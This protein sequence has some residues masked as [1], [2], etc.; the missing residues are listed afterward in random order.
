MALNQD[1]IAAMKDFVDFQSHTRFHPVLTTCR[2][3]ECGDEI[4]RSKKEVEKL[5]AKEC[6]HLSYPNGDYTEREIEIVKR[7][8]YRSAR[9]IDVGWNTINTDPYRLKITGIDDDA[10]INMLAAQ[11]TGVIPYLGYLLKGSF[12]GRHPTIRLNRL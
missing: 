3:D 4:A 6:E 5:T 11:M 2:D 12:N 1:E 8:G 7:A 10:S 9:T